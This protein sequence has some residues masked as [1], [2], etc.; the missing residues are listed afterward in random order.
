M[1]MVI[2]LVSKVVPNKSRKV[3]RPLNRKSKNRR[4][5][6]PP[7]TLV[8]AETHSNVRPDSF[9]M[10]FPSQ[11]LGA[12][13]NSIIQSTIDHRWRKTQATRVKEEV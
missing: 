7:H 13:E 3:K 10:V 8:Q 11:N 9:L 4:I 5:I 1:E 2:H 6:S 12:S